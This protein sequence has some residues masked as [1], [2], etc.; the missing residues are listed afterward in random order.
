MPIDGD[1]RGLA[2]YLPALQHLNRG[3][4]GED[5]SEEGREAIDDEA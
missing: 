5:E 1:G 4:N 3:S 2:A